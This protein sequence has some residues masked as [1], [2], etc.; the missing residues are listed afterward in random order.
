MKPIHNLPLINNRRLLLLSVILCFSLF[1]FAQKVTI[2]GTVTDSSLNRIIPMASVS[3]LRAK[4]SILYYSVRTDASGKFMVAGV[5]TGKYI[6]LVSYTPY[7]DYIQQISI[8]KTT[9]SVIDLKNINMLRKAT[10]LNEVIIKDKM[11]AAVT[12]KGDT[13]EFA[14]DSFKVEPNARV[15]DL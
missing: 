12:M 1:A 15:E 8:D 5:D 11:V 10:L 4:D 3:I 7:A 13:V 9:P 14:A 2:G 6:I